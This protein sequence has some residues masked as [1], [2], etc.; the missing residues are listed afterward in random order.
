L[1]RKL[2][3]LN[4]ALVALAAAGIWQLRSS[5]QVEK[6]REQATLHKAVKA[7]PPPAVAPLATLPPVR[8]AD[9]LDIAQKD[10]FTRD[11]NP[12]VVVETKAPPPKPMPPLPVF[13]GVLNL[14]DGPTVI[15]SE[16]KTS[17]HRDFRPGEKV[18]EFTLVAVNSDEIVLEW[19]GK[20][21]RKRLEELEDRSGAGTSAPAAASTANESAAAPPPPPPAASQIPAKAEPG[22]DIGR[23]LHACVAGDTSPG[24]TVVN[25]LKKVV[26]PGMFGQ[27]CWWEPAK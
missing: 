25:G 24:G 12:T 26:E 14:G 10:L 16:K 18:G 6:R 11:R 17:P 3:L 21:I 15:L 8:P 27:Q 9:Y 22:V 23:G 2:L 1:K 19:D 5:W 13:H 7:L 4:L 20:Q